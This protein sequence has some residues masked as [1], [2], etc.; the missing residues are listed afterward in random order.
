MTI[1]LDIINA[2]LGVVGEEP[3]STESQHPTVLACKPVIQ[4]VNKQFQESGWWFN[5]D[6]NIVLSPDSS[7]IITLPDETLSV[8]TSESFGYVWRG[9]KLYDPMNH[10]YQIAEDVTCTKLVVLLDVNDLPACAASY[11]LAQAVKTFYINDDYDKNKVRELDV[12]VLRAWAK[13]NTEERKVTRQNRL[14][15]PTASMILS[16]TLSSGRTYNSTYIGGAG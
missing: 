3:V 9:N 14:K 12:E 6:H 7:G 8:Q 13:V 4:R 11:V 16:G 5:T 2:M 15:S 10:T 1:E